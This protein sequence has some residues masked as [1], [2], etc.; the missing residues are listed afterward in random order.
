VDTGRL[1]ASWARVA[2]HGA[3]VPGHFYAR[4]FIAHPELRDMFPVSMAAQHDR[5]V[6]AL[7]AV[8]SNVDNLPAVVPVVEGLGRDHR[9]FDVRP[10]HFPLVGEALVGTLAHFLGED[11]TPDLAADWTEAYQLV[12]GVMIG[13]ANAVENT[14]AWWDTEIIDHERRGFDVAVLRLRP[15]THYPF[16]A[17]QSVSLE[18]SLRPRVWRSFSVANAPRADGTL[19]LHVKAVPGG[20][21]SNALVNGVVPGDLVRL[22][23]PTG[24]RLTLDG[25]TGRSMLLL[26]G[27]TGLAPMKALIEELAA[28]DPPR[29]VALFVG[30]RTSSDL[31]DMPSLE[32]MGQLLPWLGIQPVLSHDAY[33]DIE[34]GTPV[35]AALRVATWRESEIYV[36][37]PPAMVSDSQTRLIA[38]GIPNDR[39]HFEDFDADQYRAKPEPQSS[40][41]ANGSTGRHGVTGEVLG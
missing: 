27:G 14:P 1:R 30:A 22:G 11:W 12:S 13:A 2:M 3:Q 15:Q 9:K 20:Q 25:D 4:L 35:E 29:R 38:A 8:V 7:G 17:G 37:G 33:N 40:R 16:R 31:Y 6:G 32:R 39:I 21:V 34:R 5:L 36:C 41:P 26:A 18:T 23:S 10:E 24:N 19:D 28:S